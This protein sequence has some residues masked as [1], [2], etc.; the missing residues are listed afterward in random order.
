[1]IHVKEPCEAD[2]AFYL[3]AGKQVSFNVPIGV[4]K[5]YYATGKDFYGTELLFGDNTQY[6]SSDEL[7]TFYSDSEYYRGHT[8]TL[9]ST[10]NGNFETVPISEDQFPKR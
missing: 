5:L 9:K 3:K 7:L 6:F 1:M 4:Y 2:V 10:L 8:I